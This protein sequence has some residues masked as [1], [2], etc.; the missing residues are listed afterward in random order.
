MLGG[1]FHNTKAALSTATKGQHQ[2]LLAVGGGQC[3][4]NR[5]AP[6]AME[7]STDA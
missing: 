7:R 1:T 2:P 3:P 5:M 4:K 6:A